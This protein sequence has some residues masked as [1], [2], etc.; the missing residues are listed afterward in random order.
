MS[1]KNISIPPF[2][3]EGKSETTLFDNFGF[4]YKLKGLLQTNPLFYV[5]E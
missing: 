5:S 4:Y 3:I 1:G 2:S